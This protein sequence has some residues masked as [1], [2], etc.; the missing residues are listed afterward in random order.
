M[1]SLAEN[2]GLKEFSDSEPVDWD[3]LAPAEPTPDLAPAEAKPDAPLPGTCAACGDVIIRE[4]GARGRMPK[5]H[6]DCRPTKSASTSSGTSSA[7][8]TRRSNKIEAEATEALA[9]FEG[10][11]TKSAI[12]LSM[13]DKYD[14]FCLMVGWSQIKP[15]LFGVLKKYAGFRKEVL[16]WQAGGSIAGL[17]VSV[18]MVIAPIAA[19]HGLIP[20]KH[21]AQILVNAPFTL[22]KIMQKLNEGSAGL[23]SLME[24][25]FAA[26]KQEQE[27]KA[28]REANQAHPQPAPTVAP[29]GRINGG[30]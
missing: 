9:A 15:N 23:T 21:I 14:A 17:I 29:M 27:Q 24:E 12:M 28:M 7:V 3:S 10:L 4:P 30:A 18:I 2:P 1:T 6:P 13:V 16:S 25:Q 5:Y 19:H 26:A 8:G 11:V 20:G 22:H